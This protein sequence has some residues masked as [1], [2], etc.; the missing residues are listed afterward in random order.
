MIAKADIAVTRKEFYAA[1]VVLW[2]FV[3]FALEPVA[4]QPWVRYV[5]WGCSVSLVIAYAVL[6]W[7]NRKTDPRGD[8]SA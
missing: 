5:V 3:S 4:P 6:A 1:L 2:M 8:V 7:R